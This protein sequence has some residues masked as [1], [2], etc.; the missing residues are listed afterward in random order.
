MATTNLLNDSLDISDGYDGIVVVNNYT[1]RRGGTSLNVTGYPLP[2]IRAGHV[3]IKETA[4]G[5]LRPM[6]ITA[7]A[8]NGVATTNTL[9]AGSAY[10]NGT[11]TNV[12]LSGGSGTGALGTVV[13]AGTVVTGVTI[14]QAGSGYTVG[15]ALGVPGSFAG[16]TGTG[17]SVTVATVSSVAGGYA[18][19]PAGFTYYGHAVQSVLTTKPMVGITYHGEINNLVVAPSAG[20]FSLATILTAL[21]AALPHMMYT[22]DNA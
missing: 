2:N 14:T 17:A 16:G 18:A 10:T 5:E 22:G 7:P 4:G 19:L 1:S 8:P 11:Y 6:P 12:P 15:N 20:V 9:V 21:K 13:V 3:I